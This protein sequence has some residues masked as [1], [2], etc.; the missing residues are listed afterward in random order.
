MKKEEIWFRMLNLVDRLNRSVKEPGW[1]LEDKNAVYILKDAFLEKLLIEK[2][3][4]VD[5]TL[6]YIPYLR[7]SEETKNRAGDL[8]RRNGNQHSF[9][10]YLKQIRPSC[11]DS[12]DPTK[13][14]IEVVARCMEQTFSLHMPIEKLPSIYDVNT[15]PCKKWIPSV[16]FHHQQIVIM[17]ELYQQLNDFL[18]VEK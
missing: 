15:I 18:T 6:Y 7:Y 16:E 12:E 4:E 10:Y 5:V 1:M 3:E 17:Q 2:P 13:A 11:A 14:S 9:E 8:M